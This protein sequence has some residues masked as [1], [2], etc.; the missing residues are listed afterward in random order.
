MGGSRISKKKD[1]TVL[2]NLVTKEDRDDQW[3]TIW[4]L[5]KMT[6]AR[7]K[8]WDLAEITKYLISHEVGVQT[9]KTY[10]KSAHR[11][12][13]IKDAEGAAAGTIGEKI[14]MRA[15]GGGIN[16][17]RATVLCTLC[18]SC[19]LALMQARAEVRFFG[20]KNWALLR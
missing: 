14:T 19:C 8:N 13:E 10:I 9:E 2:Q 16:G 1:N 17:K 11:L 7:D 20:V 15:I 6:F 4:Y 18:H 3:A 5:I 12:R